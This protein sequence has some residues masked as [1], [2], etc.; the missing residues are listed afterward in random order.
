MKVLKHLYEHI[1]E[2]ISIILFGV[3]C[4]CV[5]AQM[6]TR[7]LTDFSLLYSDELS[8]FCYIWVVFLCMS[9]CEKTNDHFNVTVFLQPVKGMANE[10]LW[11]VMRVF[12]L[13]VYIYLFYWACK[14][15]VFE[16]DTKSA[17]M[18]ISMSI[19]AASMVVGFFLGSIRCA[20]NVIKAFKHAIA[21]AR[22]DK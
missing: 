6:F 8:R 7:I 15:C 5:A 18:E 19:V 11:I 22:K 3:M 16:Q 1:E 14:F 10:I 4:V 9:L 12:C 21:I 17:S 13:A 2:D 20:I